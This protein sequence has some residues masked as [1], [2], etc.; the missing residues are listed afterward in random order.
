MA[1]FTL[2]CDPAS[3]RATLRVDGKTVAE[4]SLPPLPAPLTKLYIRGNDAQLLNN[5]VV[6]PGK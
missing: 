4:T 6:S 1:K 2:H 5:I 3:R